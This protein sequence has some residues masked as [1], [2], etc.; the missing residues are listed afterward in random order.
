MKVDSKI[1]ME[2]SDMKQDE[3]EKKSLKTRFNNPCLDQ[4]QFILLIND[5]KK[6]QGK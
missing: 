2:G 3:Q 4:Y 5:M 6:V 1:E